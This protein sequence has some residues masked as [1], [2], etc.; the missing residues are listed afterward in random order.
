MSASHEDV[1]NT[2]SEGGPLKRTQALLRARDWLATAVN[3][4]I[5]AGRDRL[6][7]LLEAARSAGVSHVTLMKAV[8]EL[9]DRGILSVNHRSGIR[10]VS[11][12]AGPAPAHHARLRGTKRDRVARLI[13]ADIGRGLYPTDTPLPPA[14]VLR[15]R[16]GVAPATLA[17]A[18]AS[19]VD[20]E[21]LAPYKRSFRPVGPR[22]PGTGGTIVLVARGESPAR[23]QLVSGRTLNHLRALEQE[24]L[25][26]TVSLTVVPCYYVGTQIVGARGVREVLERGRAGLPVLGAMVWDVGLDPPF[27]DELAPVL[28]ECGRPV[29]VLEEVG[30]PQSWER[31]KTGPTRTFRLGLSRR[32]GQV[33]GRHLFA[34]GHRR[35]LFVYRRSTAIW[36]APRLDGLRSAF[37][38]H[39]SDVAVEAVALDSAG[40]AGRAEIPEIPR[41]ARALERFQLARHGQAFVQQAVRYGRIDSLKD[42]LDGTGDWLG[43]RTR[44]F[45]ALGTAAKDLSITAWVGANDEVA[46]DCLDLLRSS[47]R[48]VPADCSLAGFDDCEEASIHRLTSYNFNGEAYIR[49]MME[50]LLR[51]GWARRDGSVGEPIE[52]DGLIMERGTTA[53]NPA[54]R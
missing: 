12:S 47:G 19:L 3:A 27:Q 36:A 48:R 7:T 34:L 8:H 11:H 18:L 35:I 53:R 52:I 9:R 50:F 22:P 31:P 40:A 30:N 37:S 33:M 46:L 38:G 15:Q 21:A 20:E 42:L 10:I 6:P 4:A 5:T 2:R 43:A 17:H 32:S 49:A 29:A 24:C 44:L 51:P 23:L 28:E 14:K 1:L 16:Y 45:A 13:R 26:A 39:G 25:R 41:T 54:N